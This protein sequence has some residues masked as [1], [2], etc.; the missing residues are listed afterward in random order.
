MKRFILWLAAILSGLYLLIVGP[1]IDPIPFIDEAIMLAI[2]VKSMA[3]L[4]CDV[5]RFI[6]F[7]SKGKKAPDATKARDMTVDV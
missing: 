4:G 7:M 3:H 2:F 5:R 6:P 1:L